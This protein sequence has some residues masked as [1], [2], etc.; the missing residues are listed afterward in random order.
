MGAV[1]TPESISV[2]RSTAPRP[3]LWRRIAARCFYSGVLIFGAWA[4]L[5]VHF[6]GPKSP[7]LRL[8]IELGFAALTISASFARCN[9]WIR[10]AWCVAFLGVFLWFLS[11]RPS[12][13]RDWRPDIAIMPRVIIEGDRVRFTAYRD[14]DYRMRDDFT[15]RYQEREVE[16]SHLTSVD[17]FVSYWKPGA[18]AHTF[19]SFRFDNAPPVCISIEARREKGERFAA[20]PSLFKQFELIYVVGEER[21]IVRVRTNFRGE[22][23]YLYPLRISPEA[24]RRLFLVYIA[25]MNKLA[26][27]PEFYH[28]LRN[29]CTANIVRNADVAG[30]KAPFDY[31]FLLNGLI[32]RYLYDND[33]VD[34]TLPFEELREKSRI[35]DAAKSAGD[36]DFSKR[37]RAVL[38]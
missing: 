11:L 15:V 13:Q 19:L 5:A 34:R 16:L 27:Q 21:D 18:M 33:L 22:D 28:L 3:K 6:A 23:V 24:A 2:Q 20:L 17:L 29:S 12:H 37:I 25:Q 1:Q 38:R 14:C 9:R 32:D 7:A 4:I 31:R 35:T 10:W 8:A 30:H 36:E 26:D